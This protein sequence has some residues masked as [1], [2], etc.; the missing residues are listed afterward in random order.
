MSVRILRFFLVLLS[1][2]HI[3]QWFYR[4]VVLTY[5]KQKQIDLKKVSVEVGWA[6]RDQPST[7][8]KV[9][10]GRWCV[11]KWDYLPQLRS[12]NGR[13]PNLDSKM[14]PTPMSSKYLIEFSWRFC[15]IRVRFSNFGTSFTQ[16]SLTPFNGPSG[17]D[18]R[19]H[20]TESHCVHRTS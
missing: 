3:F 12:W 8:G 5:N 1:Y 17:L 7:Y 6:E 4:S 13:S 16:R 15:Q 18:S 20:H 14:P 19:Y 10:F 2:G 9:Y 11:S